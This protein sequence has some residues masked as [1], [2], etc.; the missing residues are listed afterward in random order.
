MTKHLTACTCKTL[1]TFPATR[2]PPLKESRPLDRASTLL[3]RSRPISFYTSEVLST[4][5]ESRNAPPRSCLHR[6]RHTLLRATTMSQH[7]KDNDFH[8]FTTFRLDTSLLSDDAHTAVCGGHKSDIYL[9]PHHFDRLRTAATEV[10]GFHYP[11]VMSD[12]AS[13]ER[14]I[15]G[16]IK[17]SQ[18]EESITRPDIEARQQEAIVNRGKVSWWPDGRLE[19]ML[20]PVP[21]SSPNLL[22]KSFDNYPVPLW[23]VVL[24]SQ[25]TE[26]DLYLG[27]KTSYRMVYDR[28]RKQ[29]GLDPKST[30]EVLLYDTKCDIVDGSITTA[31]FYR[32]SNWVT[33]H[34]GGLEGTTRRFALEAGL[35]STASSGVNRGSLRDGETIWLS[36]AFR[37]FFPATFRAS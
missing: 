3:L 36:N 12:L 33:P 14:E 5:F 19:V 34:N 20:L 29:A 1:D 16:A 26:M 28:A 21:R 10:K 6:H 17:D 9:L 18:F 27:T 2:K 15:H 24:D 23:T 30:T 35:C 13:F 4:L 37:G 25:P 32:D 22:P 31:Y 8:I 11:D 7:N